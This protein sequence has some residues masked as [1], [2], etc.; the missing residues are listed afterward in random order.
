[1][2]IKDEILKQITDFKTLCQE[3]NIEVLYAFGSSTTDKFDS[4]ISDIDSL[5]EIDESDPN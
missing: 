1:M 2:I 5:V 4:V 3:H